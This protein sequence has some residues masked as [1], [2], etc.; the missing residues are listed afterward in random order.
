MSCARGGSLRFVSRLFIFSLLVL[1]IPLIP[2][3]ASSLEASRQDIRYPSVRRVIDGDTIVIS[4][5]EHVRY[6]GIDAPEK[7]EPF[8]EEAAARNRALLSGKMVKVVVCPEEPRDRHGRLL[9]FVYSGGVNVN[10]A[11]VREGLARK[12]IIPPCGADRAGEFEKAEA[13]ARKKGLGIWGK[14]S[15][16][17]AALIPVIP[18]SE[19]RRHIGEYMRV[20][21]RVKKAFK[22]KDIAFLDFDSSFS[23]VIFRETLGVLKKGPAHYSGK[24][25]IISGVIKERKGRPEIVIKTPSQ[26][27]EVKP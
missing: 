1:L 27:E 18:D 5:N 21:G 11:L 3:D 20:K 8:Y 22:G 26:I 9:G 23:A 2:Q 7:N 25:V 13:A 19:A 17:G 12:L 16:S 15:G 14:A 10:E 6:V 4:G 24:T